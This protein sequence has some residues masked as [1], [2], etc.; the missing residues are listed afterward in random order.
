MCW[1][2]RQVLVRVAPLLAAAT[3][4]ISAGA[5]SP[6]SDYDRRAA[7]AIYS[8]Y[9]GQAVRLES[10]TDEKVRKGLTRFGVDP[11]TKKATYSL[12]FGGVK[13][14]VDSR[15]Y[16]R[17]TRRGEM[18]DVEKAG[19]KILGV[20]KETRGEIIAKSTPGDP[21]AQVAVRRL[22]GN[23]VLAVSQRR[24]IK[25]DPLAADAPVSRKFKSLLAFAE[26][27]DLLRD[28]EGFWAWLNRF[29]ALREETDQRLAL[30]RFQLAANCRQSQQ[31][32]RQ[33]FKLMEMDMRSY[34]RAA[35]SD[36]LN[37]T[38]YR[39]T[40]SQPVLERM[41]QQR[42]KLRAEVQKLH[43]EQDPLIQEGIR[44]MQA[45]TD[46]AEAQA[47]SGDDDPDHQAEVEKAIA[48]CQE[49]YAVA[50][51]DLYEAAGRFETDELQKAIDEFK[52]A[53]NA[54]R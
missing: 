13:D 35:D 37:R 25:E 53:T 3:L 43:F 6:L 23:V 14:G 22:V 7:A 28:E 31:L 36:L 44:L 15:G 48:R 41:R 11:A 4:C 9:D 17:I 5:Q 24:P 47:K 18:S 20:D 54:V 42:E 12:D 26:Q 46:S 38:P 33:W 21:F 40:I 51:L 2:V 1:R 8:C 29:R 10:I 34:P 45:L 30:I 32:R 27:F 39:S 16:I 49:R 50:K 52:F 19:Y